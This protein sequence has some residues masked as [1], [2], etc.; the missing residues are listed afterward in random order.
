MRK[1]IT[2]LTKNEIRTLSQ[3]L[4][5]PTWD[6]P[7]APC[8]SS[9]IPYGSIIT[10]DQLSRVEQAEAILR[11]LGLKTLRVRDHDTVARIEIPREDFD[12]VLNEQNSAKITESFKKIGYDWVTMDIL[13]FRSGSL[14][15]TLTD[16]VK[17]SHRESLK[18]A[19]NE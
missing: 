2:E 4:G 15:E 10:F 3:E 14:N 6:K 1:S 16:D 7:A 18:R 11:S 5:L 12:K 17:D 9:R 8:L 19:Q 13:G